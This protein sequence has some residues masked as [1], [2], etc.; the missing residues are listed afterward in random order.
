ML[1]AAVFALSLVASV[2]CAPP[3]LSVHEQGRS[4]NES[5]HA[6]PLDLSIIPEQPDQAPLGWVLYKQCMFWIDLP[7]TSNGSVAIA[8]LR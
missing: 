1:A 6:I 4:V 5:A 2:L 8:F 3:H 7:L